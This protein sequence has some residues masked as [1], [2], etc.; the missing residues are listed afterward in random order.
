MFSVTVLGS[1]SA[2]PTANRFPTSQ[3]LNVDYNYYLIDCGEGTQIQ[4]RKNKIKM[5]RISCIFISH[6]HGDHIFGLI[7]LLNTLQLYAR[8]EPIQIVGPKA[9]KDFIVFQ[10]GL[11]QTTLDY[12]LEFIPLIRANG[13]VVFED[14]KISVTAYKMN[15]RIECWGYVFEEKEKNKNL[16]IEAIKSFDIPIN[17]Y[18]LIKAGNDYTQA[19]GDVI[20]NEK[21]TLKSPN[22][23]RYVFFTDTRV[24]NKLAEKIYG[25]DLLYHETTFA[26]DLLDRAKATYHSTTVETAKFALKANVKKLMIG[27]YSSRYTA[28]NHL[29]EEVKVHFEN[30]VLAI[31]D[32]TYEI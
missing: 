19:N 17:Y 6:M 20:P 30:S 5:Q 2:I 15:H 3:L 11:T 32:E 18:S 9:L 10:L 29:L 1:N 21:L 16:D 8:T 14:K 27:H 13:K 23:K 28:L 4:L 24:Q 31:E 25:A 22:V 12:P 7:G 26:H